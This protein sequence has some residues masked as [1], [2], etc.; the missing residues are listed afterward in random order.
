MSNS[1]TIFIYSIAMYGFSN[2]IVFGSGPFRV[3]ERVRSF[4]TGIS[5]HFGKLF[6]CMMCFPANLGWIAS[7]LDWFLIENASITPFNILLCGTNLW[8][9]ALIFDCIFTSGIV[10]LIHNFESFFES[11]AEGNSSLQQ[12]DTNNDI[13]ELND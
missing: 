13:I 9:I 1:L 6:S 8:W 10:W 2:M 3:F 12:N 4:T 11:I 5:E 7:L